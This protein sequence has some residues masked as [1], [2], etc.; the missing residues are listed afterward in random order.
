M[1]ESWTP[2]SG[3]FTKVGASMLN[4]D[5]IAMYLNKA[6]GFVVYGDKAS[7]TTKVGGVSSDAIAIA[8]TSKHDANPAIPIDRTTVRNSTHLDG[9]P[10][11]DFFTSKNGGALVSRQDRLEHNNEREFVELR[12]EL[13]Q[14]RAELARKGI[15]EHYTPY[16]GFYDVFRKGDIRYEEEPIGKAL[17]VASG[18][19]RLSIVVADD[20]FKTTFPGDHLYLV[21]PTTG[22]TGIAEIKEK[23]PDGQTLHFMNEVPFSVTKGVVIYK[24]KGVLHNGSYTFGEAATV[25]IDKNATMFT[26]LNDDTSRK[27]L[28]ISKK[29]PGYAYTFRIPLQMQKN[30][31]S[32]L[33][34]CIEAH[35][36]PG[37][38]T[39]YIINEEDID[40][41]NEAVN[42]G[43]TKD[44][45]TLE[46]LIVAKS[47]PL[48][49]DVSRG[50]Y[51]ATFDF[52]DSSKD[53]MAKNYGL[54]S[55]DCYPFLDGDDAATG[56]PVRYCMIISCD[57]TSLNDVSYYDVE[58]LDGSTGA[59]LQTNNTLYYYDTS[60]SS[61]IY[62]NAIVN[63][64]DLFYGI[65]LLKAVK[66]EFTPYNDGMYSAKFKEPEPVRSTYARL[67]MRVNREGMFKA[68]DDNIGDQVDGVTL[69][70][71]E[72]E[73]YGT[74]VLD[75]C[76]GNE[77]VIGTNIRK[78][79][80]VN[81][82]ALTF[83]KGLHV[84]KDDP[85]YPIGY[86][87]ALKASLEEWD[88]IAC[89]M[90][91]RYIQRYPM[92]LTAVMPDKYKSA[93]SHLSDRLIF[94]TKLDDE[95]GNSVLYNK[96]ELEIYWK[97]TCRNNQVQIEN[98]H[99]ISTFPLAGSIHDLSLSL[100][101][102]L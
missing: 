100:D 92:P 53:A 82:M 3:D 40:R 96:F 22:L 6:K 88:P 39:C 24:S 45:H 63:A 47:Q 27:T 56:R 91:T 2:T 43:S 59:N 72:L 58:F 101:H 90:V 80:T 48:V 89:K 60:N 14:L 4:M 38:L 77:V 37:A 79:T 18:K 55:P 95:D 33:D 71:K 10:F 8:D 99:G 61:P 44:G 76:A 1:S 75:G 98:S 26:G 83:Q 17:G 28:Q 54:E 69:N 74:G 64:Y 15:I 66:H 70:A 41:W 67:T 9:H 16:S 94:E 78:C 86:K 35:G 102:V 34:I 84:E 68:I 23:D 57:P 81:D 87:V 85:I 49:P 30:Y 42:T 19:P 7:D 93:E 20:I 46:S 25:S 97:K 52:Y 62:T 5:D 50:K 65:T 31:L 73:A 13:Y 11:T 32:K 29:Y 21:D 12:D 36:T 51:I